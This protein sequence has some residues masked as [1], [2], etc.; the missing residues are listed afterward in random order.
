MSAA[1][2]DDPTA[3]TRRS[4]DLVAADYA[5]RNATPQPELVA[6]RDECWRRCGRSPPRP[7]AGPAPAR[8][9]SSTAGAGPGHLTASFV[10]AGAAA[11]A[12]YASAAMV[13]LARAR[14]VPVVRGDLRWP[15][16][17]DGVFEGVWSAASL[18]HVPREQVPATLR[19][20]RRVTRPGGG[21]ALSTATGGADGW[22]DSPYDTE[23][24]RAAPRWFVFHEEAALSALLAEAGWRVT[25][26][27]VWAGRRDWLRI[28]AVAT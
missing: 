1:T 23:G 18:L 12:L 21:L 20:W 10:A 25:S 26:A 6:W 15:P 22:E 17:A 5:A 11:V 16:F 24:G 14:G 28:R 27:T 7:V 13:S 2:P 8:C 19:E 9:G 4:Y 3:V